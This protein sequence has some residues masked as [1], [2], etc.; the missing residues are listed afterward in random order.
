[1][2]RTEHLRFPEVP[3]PIKTYQRKHLLIF[4]VKFMFNGFCSLLCLL[5]LS[6]NRVYFSNF[7]IFC[8]RG[9]SFL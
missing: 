5:S 8:S 6:E 4:Y 1:M 9:C 2:T 7:R 3:C